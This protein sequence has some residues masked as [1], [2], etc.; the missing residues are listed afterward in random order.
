MGTLGRRRV[1][2]WAAAATAVLA[3]MLTATPAFAHARVTIRAHAPDGRVIEGASIATEHARATTD[4]R[5]VAIIELP[6]G[7]A[8]LEVTRLG[9]APDTVDLAVTTDRD[10]TLDVTLL[11]RPLPIQPIIVSTAR[12]PRRLEE[13]SER[14]EVLAGD[15]VS[16]KGQM[17]PGDIM[18]LLSEMSGVRA[19]P[20]ASAA[21]GASL[22]IQ[23]L[24]GHYAEILTD[25]LPLTGA[26]APE[27]GLI[28]IVPIDLEQAEVV[29]GAATALYG[30]TALG[31]VLNLISRRPAAGHDQSLALINQTSRSG[32][33]GAVWLARQRS[34]RWG[35]TLL[36]GAHHQ[37]RTDVDRDGWADLPGVTRGELRP[38]A[39]WHGDGGRSMMATVGMMAETRNGGATS[40]P[41]AGFPFHERI[42]TQRADAGVIARWPFGD[43]TVVAVRTSASG[44]RRSHDADSPV[45]G[46]HYDE[47]RHTLFTEATWSHARGRVVWLVGAALRDDAYRNAGLKGLDNENTVP[48]LMAQATAMATSWLSATATERVDAHPRVGTIGSQRAAVLVHAGHTLEARLSAGAGFAVPTPFTEEAQS[49]S[50]AR[51]VPPSG[52]RTE[53]GRSASLDVTGRAG[54]LEV[55]GTLFGST[56]DHAVLLDESPGQPAGAVALINAAGPTRTHGAELFAVYRRE[57][58]VATSTYAWL[59]ASEVS[60]ESGH[61]E[62]AA[63]LPRHTA[64]LDVA[65]D[66]DESGTRVGFELF[67]IGRQVLQHDPERTESVPYATCGVLASQRIGRV[68]AYVNAENL[69][70]VRQT[71]WAPFVLP[72][73]GP[74]GRQTV[75]LWAPL[76]GRTFNAGA[77][78]TFR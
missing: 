41:P 77:Q 72:A 31:G 69:G 43:A 28:Q 6:E 32:S 29:K 58:I 12:V 46:D 78:L 9:F 25:G 24:R 74:G 5:G 67:Y 47:L 16:E 27:L 55:N 23:G 33:D 42:E 60:P 36:G 61:R 51:L 15:D 40:T 44:E 35:W 7:P 19:Q 65:W 50:L 21:G 57:P 11:E 68:T 38:R 13:E 49:I 76:E 62:D 53:R 66:E 3:W 45:A 18:T 4:A 1:A 37:T 56:I 63:L 2:P 64:A 73:P 54:A 52:L 22:R 17:H 30:P 10:T 39:F 34:E 75:D 20:I 26:S 70:N 48:A 71:R 8:R 14:I 59:R